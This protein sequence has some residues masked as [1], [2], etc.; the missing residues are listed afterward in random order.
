MGRGGGRGRGAPQ[1]LFEPPTPPAW[2][3][4]WSSLVPAL[5]MATGRGKPLCVGWVG[6]GSVYF[7]A[8]KKATLP[9]LSHGQHP[10]TEG[11]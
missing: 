10:T 9:N 11:K 3:S 8:K 7:T 1:V 2:L 6:D 5:G 4:R